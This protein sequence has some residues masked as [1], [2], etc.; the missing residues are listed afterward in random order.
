MTYDVENDPY[1]DKDTK[2]LRN[3]FGLADQKAL[4]EVEFSITSTEI[5][6]LEEYII[7]G[8]FDLDHLCRIHKQIF[9][10]LYDWA[11][12]IRTVDMAKDKTRFAHAEHIVAY[13]SDLFTQL[14]QEKYLKGL[15]EGDFIERFSH[16]YSEVNI[17]HPFRE[18]NGRTQRAFFT[19]LARYNGYHV[20]W[21]QMNQNDNIAASIAAY[22]GDEGP[23]IE[24][25]Y[26]LLEWVHEE[27]WNIHPH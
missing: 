2:I 12:E 13:A 8:G 7:D 11:G 27:Y 16:Y 22:N 14:E 25:L 5:A 17:L 15:V 19:L 21:D 18:G 6:I 26:P 23:L 9:G 10:Q 1:I 20:A 24:I 3:I 4:D